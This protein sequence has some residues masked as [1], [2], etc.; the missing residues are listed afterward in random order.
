LETLPCGH[1][2]CRMCT[3][4]CWHQD[5]QKGVYSCPQCRL[6][7]LTPRHAMS[8]T[9]LDEVVET[10][11]KTTLQAPP[12]AFSEAHAMNQ[13]KG[14]DTVSAAEE[15][16]EKQTEE[17]YKQIIQNRENEIQKLKTA[18][19]SYKEY[20]QTA[21][22]EGYRIFTEL[23]KSMEK[24]HDELTW[25]IKAQANAAVSRADEIMMELEQEIAE[26]RR[27][28]MQDRLLSENPFPFHQFPP[29]MKSFQS[30]SAA[31][32]FADSRTIKY[33]SS[34]AFGDV[35]KA[36]SQLREQLETLMNNELEKILNQDVPFSFTLDSSS[37][38]FSDLEKNSKGFSFVKKGSFTFGDLANNSGGCSFVKK[39][40]SF[41]W[42][43]A[44]IEVF[45]TQATASQNEQED[46]EDSDEDIS[47]FN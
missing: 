32:G 9:A 18:V 17:K 39:D 33:S 38:T 47:L 14:Q 41:S 12:P 26:I 37:F 6:K 2:I 11:K 10:L 4:D 29:S 3:V 23:I 40:P 45:C 43:N 28:D 34:F 15:Q 31:R 8:N 16:A 20:V 42:A 22:E 1:Q 35:L 36:L 44:E 13:H 25:L 46:H 19:E 24:K 30:V 7:A 21:I 27:R 5:D